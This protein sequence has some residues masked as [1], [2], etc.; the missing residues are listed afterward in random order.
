MDEISS[1]AVDYFHSEPVASSTRKGRLIDKMIAEMSVCA[2]DHMDD[3]LRARP[4][5]ERPKNKALLDAAETA[6]HA[7]ITYRDMVEN[8]LLFRPVIDPED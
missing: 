3:Y 2:V 8:N 4:I 5:D 1:R 7:L 6:W